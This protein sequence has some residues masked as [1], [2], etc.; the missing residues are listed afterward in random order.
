MSTFQSFEEIEAW[1]ES[2][3][4]IK[5]IRE[6]CKRE[7]VRKDFA[8]V[9][10]ITRSARS[11][12]ANIAEGCESLTVADFIKFLGYSKRSSGEVRS[13]LYDG[14][15]EMYMTQEEFEELS[16][17]TKKICSMLAKLIHYL[18]TLDNNRKR[19][20]KPE[21]TNNKKRETNNVTSS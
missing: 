16:D 6:I 3:K 2:R 20:Q 13:H 10:Q 8:F 4:L 18:Q 19:T 1:Q 11:V 17:L 5:R 15:E 12:A 14:L 9:D 21:V 7:N